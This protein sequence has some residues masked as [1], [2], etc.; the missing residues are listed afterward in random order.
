M[1]NAAKDTSRI[2]LRPYRSLRLPMMGAKTNC[3]SAY[4]TTR[5]PAIADASAKLISDSDIKNC[6]KTGMIMPKPTVSRNTVVVTK[7]RV[8]RLESNV[9]CRVYRRVVVQLGSKTITH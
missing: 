2:F 3:R 6:G 8:W 7:I 9:L 5:Y 4:E 1:E